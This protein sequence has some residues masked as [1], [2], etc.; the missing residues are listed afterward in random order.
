MNDRLAL[1]PD[2]ARQLASATKTTPQM[3]GITP[4]YLLRALPWVDVDSGVFRVNRRRTY[5]L[6]DDRISTYEHEGS[7]RVIPGD[8]R[9]VPYLRDADDAALDRFAGAFTEVTFEPGQVLIQSGDPADRLWVIVQG[10]AEKRVSGRHGEDELLQVIGDGQYFDL[11]SWTR[12]EPMPYRV[13]AL[14]RGVALCAERSALSELADGDEN[15][16]A[17]MDAYA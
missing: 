17:A 14:T 7:P 10:R 1:S 4:R 12:S 8:L 13:Q 3:R 9:E 11:E 6:G 2:A 5:V 15:L 16:R